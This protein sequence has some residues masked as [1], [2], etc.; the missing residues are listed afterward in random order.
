M[1]KPLE[2]GGVNHALSQSVPLAAWRSPANGRLHFSA[3]GF[4]LD[5][6]LLARSRG[7]TTPG[8]DPQLRR[9]SVGRS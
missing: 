5:T 9:P 8:N 4:S 7:V 3:C 2:K 6:K 1:E